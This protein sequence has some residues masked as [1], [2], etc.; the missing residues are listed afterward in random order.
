M[1]S[2]REAASPL[3]GLV[4]N[5]PFRSLLC[6]VDL[7]GASGPTV[8]VARSFVRDGGTLHLLHV[9]RPARALDLDLA[10]AGLAPTGV[11]ASSSPDARLE[12]SDRLAALAAEGER[13]VRTEIH[14]VD[15]ED[16]AVEITERARSLGVDAVVVGTHGRIGFGSVLLGSVASAVVDGCPVP[17]LVVFPGR[18]RTGRP[19]LR[20]PCRSILCP[21]ALSTLGNDGVPLAY[22][23]AGKGSTVHLL[24]A[25][26]PAAHGHEAGRPDDGDRRTAAR[27]VLEALG[28]AVPEHPGVRTEIHLV[29]SDDAA[30]TIERIAATAGADVV[31]LGTHGRRGL[32]RVRIGTVA[33]RMI[34]SGIPVV[35]VPRLSA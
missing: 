29:E 2:P 15:A 10:L 26:L 8:A 32:D 6:A 9:G 7:S 22:A 33:S 12:A 5:A 25:W 16:A 14:V 19:G 4:W 21:T 13:Q 34:R 31:V 35:L 1:P 27:R 28:R 17:A 11:P 23:L 20:P 24:H 30:E 3:P 18:E